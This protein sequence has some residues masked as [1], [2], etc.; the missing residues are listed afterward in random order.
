VI[1]GISDYAISTNTTTQALVPIRGFITAVKLSGFL[2]VNAGAT[3][4]YQA[5]VALS[6]GAENVQIQQSAKVNYDSHTIAFVTLG[7]SQQ[8]INANWINTYNEWL[9]GLMIPVEVGQPLTLRR[10]GQGIL[11]LSAECFVHITPR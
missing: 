10:N 4:V 3:G 7:V 5:Y 9:P 6:Y 8:V 11:E 2:T 1:L